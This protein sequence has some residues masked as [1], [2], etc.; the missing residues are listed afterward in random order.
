MFPRS[1]MSVLRVAIG[2][3]KEQF[4]QRTAPL[5]INECH[6][7]DVMELITVVVITSRYESDYRL[8]YTANLWY[9]KT[10]WRF[11]NLFELRKTKKQV[12]FR[13]INSQVIKVKS[14]QNL[15]IGD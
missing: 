10:L 13:L 4:E 1:Y 2:S 14:P 7:N 15:P 11:L 6:S 8:H 12:G 5:M 9:Y 3:E